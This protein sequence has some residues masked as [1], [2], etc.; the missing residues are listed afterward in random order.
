MSYREGGN[1]GVGFETRREPIRGGSSPTSLSVMVSNP[2]PQSPLCHIQYLCS[3]TKAKTRGFS[4]SVFK[5]I[6]LDV[7]K[8]ER[9]QT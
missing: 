9:V 4:K 1:W 5:K 8:T 6:A 3:F 7:G 2:T